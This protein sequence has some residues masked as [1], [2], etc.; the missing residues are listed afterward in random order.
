MITKFNEMLSII[1]IFNDHS[2][3]GVK[4]NYA[5]LL[6]YIDPRLI[7]GFCKKLNIDP[8]CIIILKKFFTTHKWALDYV[9][10]SPESRFCKLD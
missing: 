10:S 5:V 6:N 9:E 4:S 8:R 7:F 3:A 1:S 2:V